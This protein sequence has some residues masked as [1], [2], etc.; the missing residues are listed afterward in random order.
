MKGRK[1]RGK[2]GKRKKK[3]KES[4]F[5]Y[6]RKCITQSLSDFVSV[7]RNKINLR[8]TLFR[9]IEKYQN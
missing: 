5:D 3:G 2:K 7:V 6:V 1:K 9:N 4:F 8:L